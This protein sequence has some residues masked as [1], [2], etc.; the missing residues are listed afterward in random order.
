[1]AIVYTIDKIWE[2]L[3]GLIPTCNFSVNSTV[4]DSLKMM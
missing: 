1:L 4:T 3:M 2:C